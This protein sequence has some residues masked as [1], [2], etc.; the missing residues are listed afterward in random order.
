MNAM[1]LA[2]KRM[3]DD[4]GGQ[5]AIDQALNG[6]EASQE[7]PT[8]SKVKL[9]FGDAEI[10]RIPFRCVLW[11]GNKSTCEL[12]EL[13][14]PEQ[15]THSCTG[16]APRSGIFVFPDFS[17]A[18]PPLTQRLAQVRGGGFYHAGWEG[19]RRDQVHGGSVD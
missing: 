17:T 11:N 12:T 6:S 16:V 13:T 1:E 5:E 9:P 8:I 2:C 3:I 19:A 4:F 7:D 14:E 15:P 10:G 18:L